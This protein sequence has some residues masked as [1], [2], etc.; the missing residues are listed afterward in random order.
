MDL[1]VE[2]TKSSIIN[3]FIELRSKK[4]LEKIT[5]KELCESAKINKSTFYSHYS[6]IY[7]LSDAIENEVVASVIQ[8]LGNPEFIFERPEEFTHRL[9]IGYLSQEHLIQTL[10]SGSRSSHLVGNIEREIK[11]LFSQK[12]PEYQ[13][14]LA[15]NVGISYA[16]Y[17]G[18]FAFN[19]NRQRGQEETIR[20]LGAIS[21]HAMTLLFQSTGMPS[22]LSSGSH[23][24]VNQI[25]IV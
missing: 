4:P 8:A 3:A 10:F 6:D 2:K 5:I 14:D 22:P 24:L 17:G 18:Y 16:V 19:E 15:V 7:A 21:R 11:K 1:R 13:D 20:L 23:N 12:Y 9:F 25:H